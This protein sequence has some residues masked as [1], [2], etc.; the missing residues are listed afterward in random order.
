MTLRLSPTTSEIAREDPRVRGRNGQTPAFHGREVL[1]D[2]VEGC[3]VRAAL[4]ERVHG[5]PL[6]FER[7]ARRWNRHQSR[8][9][10]R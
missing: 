5:C 1:P 10:P 8:S 3:D 9:S 4:Q 7:Q 2:S 6:V